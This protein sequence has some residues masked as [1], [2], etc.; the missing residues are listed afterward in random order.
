MNEAIEALTAEHE[1]LCR[2]NG[3][4]EMATRIQEWAIR[5]RERLPSWV[6]EEL[7]A[8]VATAGETRH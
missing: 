4:L 1:R 6:I 8:I 5:N 7:S 3:Q 2:L